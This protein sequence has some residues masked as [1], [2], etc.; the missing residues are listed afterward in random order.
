MKTQLS[1]CLRHVVRLSLATMLVFTAACNDA[2][3]PVETVIEPAEAPETE[4]PDAWHDKIR[5]QPYPKANNELY[6]NPPPLIVPEAMHT[7]TY[8]Q[9]ALSAN[10]AFDEAKGETLLSGQVKWNTYNPHRALTAGTWYWR[11]RNI[12]ENGTAG[13]WSDTYSFCIK[14]ELPVFVTPTFDTFFRNLPRTYPRLYCYL[15]KDRNAMS[16]KDIEEHREY[17]NLI[18]RANKAT[19]HDY[20]SYTDPYEF[21][22]TEII[23]PYV[24]FLYQACYLTDITKYREKAADIARTMIAK[25][26]VADSQLFSS[27]FNATNI[28]VI[29]AEA[30]D[31]AR[32]LMSASERQASEEIMMRVAR[33][34]YKMYCGMQENRLFDNH[35]WQHNMRILFQIAL[36]FHDHPLYSDECREMLE[37]YYELWTARAPN[38]GNNRSGLWV[39]GVG[40][41]TANVKTLHYMPSLFSA[42]TGTDFL[43]HPWYQSAGQALAYAWA[44]ESVSSSFGDGSEKNSAPDRQRV[45][46][47]DFL[48]RETRD[49]YACWYAQQNSLA[50]VQDVDLRLYRFVSPKT[51]NGDRFPADAP[52]LLW[53]KDAGEVTIHS[54]LENTE[55]DL[56]LGFRS[57]TFGSNSHTVADQNSF[58]L[59]Y[60]GEY[61]FRNGGYYVGA[62][63]QAYNLLCYRHSRGHNTILVNGIGQPFSMKAY[64]QVVRAMGGKHMAY[65]LGDA[66]KAYNGITDEKSWVE[67]FAAT[68]IEQTPENG[69]G[70]TPL[71]GY[72][73]HI[74]VIYPRTV[75]IYDELEA[76]EPVRW[77]WL[78]HSPVRYYINHNERV[79]TTGCESKNFHTVLQQFSDRESEITQTNRTLIPITETPD[80]RYPD[81]WHLTSTFKPCATNRILTVIQICDNGEQPAYIKREGNTFYCGDYTINVMLDCS[82]PAE[83][84]VSCNTGKAQF[85]YSKESPVLDGTVYPRAYSHSSLL[86]DEADGEYKVTEQ[87]DYLPISTR[88]GR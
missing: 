41:F 46:F 62:G 84:T 19:T 53:Y 35:F 52:K 54:N 68:G 5:E 56:S 29:Y 36:L 25:L 79:I 33:H 69:F 57:S 80:S 86:Y 8:V 87:T 37:Y 66:S 38:G 1:L 21:D 15:D 47:A 85:S 72:R 34:Y 23:K 45:A 59:L 63:N 65:C 43:K 7:G 88:I 14:D 9:F 49:G 60:R 20:A 16:P 32:E 48:A 77:D 50:L 10:E 44:P 2:E 76:S 6:L 11:F 75:L 39:N 40:Y 13:E 82:Q 83:L 55:Q 18:Q 24:N 30:Y 74:L 71:T 28:A 27:N 31:I 78:L 4:L 12:D 51:Y 64:G 61:I 22:N 81:L 73:R 3:L 26:P 17:A 58:K 67:T 42:L 70:E